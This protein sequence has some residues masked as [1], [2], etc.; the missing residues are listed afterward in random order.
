MWY[1]TMSLLIL[2]PLYLSV[3]C[4]FFGGGDMNG[5]RL[6]LSE[7]TARIGF[8]AVGIINGIVIRNYLLPQYTKAFQWED[9]H[10]N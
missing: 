7:T 5:I 4:D 10:E 2:D 9:E 3:L 8:A 6:I 1:V